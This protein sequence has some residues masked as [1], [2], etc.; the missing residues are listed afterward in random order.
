M[1]RSMFRSALVLAL[2][3]AAVAATSAQAAPLGFE[4]AVFVD[5]SYPGGEPLLFYDSMHKRIVFSSHSSVSVRSGSGN[6]VS[7]RLLGTDPGSDIAV[8]MG[9]CKHVLAREEEQWAREGRHLIDL[10]FIEQHTNGFE[11]FAAFADSVADVTG[12]DSSS[13]FGPP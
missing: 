4:P 9:L 12:S 11:D 13:T 8:L 6:L 7:W 2:V 5:D 3:A 1:C 10:D